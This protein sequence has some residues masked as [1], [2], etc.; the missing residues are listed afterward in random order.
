MRISLIN[1]CLALV[2][3]SVDLGT[4]LAASTFL[5]STQVNSYTLANPPF[6]K[7]FPLLYL[8]D[9]TAPL[10]VDLLS[11]MIGVASSCTSVK[12]RWDWVLAKE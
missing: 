5:V 12:L 7:N 9:I 2:L 3:T 10:R 4:T 8:I 11:S 6:P 1:F